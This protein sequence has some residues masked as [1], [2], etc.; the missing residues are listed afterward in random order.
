MNELSRDYV[1]YTEAS[2]Q[3]L[4]CLLV[5]S[6][7]YR[8]SCT[9]S[10]KSCSVPV[11]C[12]RLWGT[13]TRSSRKSSS[14]PDTACGDPIPLTTHVS[15]QDS[16]HSLGG[17]LTDQFSWNYDHVAGLWELEGWIDATA[18]Q[19]ARANYG[20][21]MVQRGDGLRIITLNTDFWYE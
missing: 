21:Y 20:A 15:A 18:A 12:T 11:Q 13:T 2:P 5:C 16:P 17:N 8:P 6:A 7:R 19:L 14:H 10:S 9:T 1:L 4:A 3:L